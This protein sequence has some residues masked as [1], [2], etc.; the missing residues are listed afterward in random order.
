[1]C[2]PVGKANY[3]NNFDCYILGNVKPV[4]GTSENVAEPDFDVLKM[5]A[6]LIFN[7]NLL[8][9]ILSIKMGRFQI[10]RYQHV[11][12]YKCCLLTSKNG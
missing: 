10:F 12:N 6:I 1:M 5:A 11:Q 3:Y 2:T 7:T 9:F 4:V 8:C